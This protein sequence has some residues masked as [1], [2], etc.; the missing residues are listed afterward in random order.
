MT[1]ALFLDIL[2]VSLLIVGIVYAVILD[3][4]FSATKENYRMLSQLI[5]QFY[6]AAQ[7][8]QDEL[9]VLKNTQERLKRELNEETEKAVLLK[10]ELK[11]VLEKIERYSLS[12][13]TANTRM[14]NKLL[15]TGEEV[16]LSKGV[17]KMI[18][19]DSEKELLT[20]LNEL[21]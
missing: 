1:L 2:V 18:L 15:N 13:S 17:N 12:V 14:M 10:E 19:S 9:T 20:A 3:S 6:S 21:K 7:K 5:E 8:T 11:G 4:H 16:A